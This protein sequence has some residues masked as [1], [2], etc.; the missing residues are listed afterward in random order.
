[1]GRGGKKDRSKQ[2]GKLSWEEYLKLSNSEK[3]RA[4]REGKA[5]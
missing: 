1:V 3:L 5:P 2:S 4:T